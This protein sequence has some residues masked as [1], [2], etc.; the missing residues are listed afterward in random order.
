MARAQPAVL[1]NSRLLQY[2]DKTELHTMPIASYSYRT[3]N[4]ELNV[5]IVTPCVTSNKWSDNFPLDL[6]LY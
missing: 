5:L 2:V 4:Y 6:P 1:G 3:Y